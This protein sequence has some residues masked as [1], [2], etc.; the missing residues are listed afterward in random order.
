MRSHDE[1]RGDGLLFYS[2]AISA[3]IESTTPVYVQSLL[4]IFCDDSQMRRWLEDTWCVEELRHGRLMR[5][6][7]EQLWP[8]LD[9]AQ[10]YAEFRARY[11]PRCDAALLRPTPAFEALAR[12][13]TEAQSAASY[14]AL[15]SYTAD[16]PL[17]ATFFEM[18]ADE[19]RHYSYFR[20][21]FAAHNEREQHGIARR[22]QVVI[23]R[24]LLVRDED[25]AVSFRFLGSHWKSAPPFAPMDYDRYLEL[26]SDV[27]E[28]HF[29]IMAAARMLMKPVAGGTWLEDLATSFVAPFLRREFGG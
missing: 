23:A 2:M 14:R 18:A 15:G 17:A 29:P 26:L 7:V 20:R 12:C 24:T 5:E 21:A 10:A 28:T 1:L 27:M 3:F 11:E 8:E 13:V 4:R 25:L 19:A 6:G 16:S 9:F 22:L